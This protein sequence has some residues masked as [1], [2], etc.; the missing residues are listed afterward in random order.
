[1]FCSCTF[2]ACA[3]ENQELLKMYE[4]D[5]SERKNNLYSPSADAK[6]LK[7]AKEMLEE[8]LLKTANDYYHA[9]II[10]QHG[11]TPSDY[12]TAQN[13][14]TKASK[15]DPNNDSAKWL[16]CAAEDRYLLS[17]GKA[18]IWG[19]Q[20]RML[21]GETEWSLEPFDRT[22]KTDAQRIQNSVRTLEQTQVKLDS[23]NAKK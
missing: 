8:G 12:K 4:N 19:T 5:Q 14:A 1:M 9:A 21:K 7:R 22:A 2:F 18:Q 17:V 20:F 11:G 6:R 16:A 13:L 15:L 3:S 10:F 23:M